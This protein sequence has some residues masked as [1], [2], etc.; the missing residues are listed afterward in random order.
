MR[1]LSCPQGLPWRNRSMREKRKIRI[2]F[3][4]WPDSDTRKQL[5]RVARR[6]P[7]QIPARRVP[8]YNLHM[9]LHFIGNVDF[10]EFACLR[11]Q[12]WQV[13]AARFELTVDCHGHFRKSRVAWLGCGEVPA[14][15][16]S[17]HD[18]L[19]LCLQPA[20]YRPEARRYNPHVT[21]AR[22]MTRSP[23][24]PAFEPVSW[25]VDNFALVESRAVDNGV[26][27]QVVETY[28]LA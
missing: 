12:A 22:K 7:V 2:F 1:L 8:D 10:D 9:T 23:E 21:S 18:E 19:G 13:R 11:R 28:P 5:V 25:K 20:G 16:S 6:M 17:L 3:A 15:L 27:Y 4:L 14:A 24:M 26:K